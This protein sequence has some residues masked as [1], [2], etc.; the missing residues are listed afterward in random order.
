MPD[1]LSRSRRTMA[2]AYGTVVAVGVILALAYFIG[3]C[4][5]GRLCS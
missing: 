1:Q 3:A 5:F 4:W 2:W